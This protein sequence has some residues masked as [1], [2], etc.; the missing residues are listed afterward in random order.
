[1]LYHSAHSCS[2]A[3]TAAQVHV[4]SLLSQT[5]LSRISANAAS[6]SK[7]SGLTA[8]Q[9][10]ARI[11][12]TTSITDLEALI[13][14]HQH[15]LNQIHISAA[16]VQTS[17]LLQPGWSVSSTSSLAATTQLI[18]E[19]SD[20]QEQQLPSHPHD[21]EAAQL[22]DRLLQ[23]AKQHV[24]EFD[25]QAVGNILYCLAS[26]Q[27]YDQ[28]LVEGLL[29]RAYNIL[30]SF[31]Q[32]SI[33]QTAWALG[34][35]QCKPSDQWL[36]R[37]V[38]R[39]MQLLPAFDQQ[40][41]SLTLWGL[42][43]VDARPQLHVLK[44]F[45]AVSLP[46]L[47]SYSPQNLAMVAYSV[48]LFGY[49]PPADWLEGLYAAS[50]QQLPAFS[51]QQLATVA[52]S[53]GKMAAVEQQLAWTAGAAAS[54]A[55]AA[56]EQQQATSSRV[57]PRPSLF[58]QQ[59]VTSEEQ[60]QDEQQELA[61][62][63]EQLQSGP[64][65]PAG[66]FLQPPQQWLQQFFS[67]T[68]PLLQHMCSQELVSMLSGLAH[69]QQ[70]PPDSWLQQL[71]SFGEAKLLQ[72]G[73]AATAAILGLHARL[74][75][76]PPA[77]W[78]RSFFAASYK[79]MGSYSHQELGS[80]AHALA[81]LCIRPNA[82]WASR[83][84]ATA[85]QQMPGSAPASTSSIVSATLALALHQQ[86]EEQ[87]QQVHGLLDAA[88]RQLPSFAVP[89]LVQLLRALALSQ[90]P[91]QLSQLQQEQLLK[92]CLRLQP[93]S[94]PQT[95]AAALHC[96]ARLQVQPSSSW[97][98]QLCNQLTTRMG[99]FQASHVAVTMWSLVRMG[100]EPDR[101]W[102]HTFLDSAAGSTSDGSSSGACGCYSPQELTMVCWALGKLRFVPTQSWLA[103]F[104]SHSGTHMHGYQAQT[105]ATL[106]WMLARLPVVPG[107]AWL[108]RYAAATQPQ[109]QHC[110]PAE[111]LCLVSSV[112]A[113]R[114]QPGPAWV[115]S[116]VAAAEASEEQLGQEEWAQLQAAVSALSG[117]SRSLREQQGASS[118]S[119]SSGRSGSGSG[120]GKGS[121]KSRTKSS[122]GA[123]RGVSAGSEGI[124]NG[125]G[126]G[127]RGSLSNGSKV[128]VVESEVAAAAGASSSS[129]N[130]SGSE[131]AASCGPGDDLQAE[132]DEAVRRLQQQG[133]GMGGAVAEGGVVV[134]DEV[135][136]EL[137]R[138]SS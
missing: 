45:L 133:A 116:A 70:C 83:M 38:Q 138:N 63:Q 79:Q 56:V 124:S 87:Q 47:H 110:K 22:W 92:A 41:V 86:S 72:L 15:Q 49:C 26:Q 54:A 44:R 12:R 135:V 134:M 74:G 89:E 127:K 18:E 128:V 100:H 17:R 130:G 55:P 4:H 58:H 8:S 119:T 19:P 27:Q 64:G 95:T 2:P 50:L 21:A 111:L 117:G 51:P 30:P 29:S 59:Q 137:P 101:A 61:Q 53:L 69:L 114:A 93:H 96:L 42:A 108:Q 20:S 113:L 16:I 6:P 32:Q 37:L 118:K 7:P 39:S 31:D 14:Q 76:C 60:Q 46:R 88:V 62:Q 3:P 10:T 81:V 136:P 80:A 99:S 78:L 1:M 48:A 85:H 105:L 131:H 115:D 106:V 33:A 104:L 9:V 57:A 97:L 107:T 43:K 77:A 52:W 68:E 90:P 122:G 11:K 28:Q 84:L 36:R 126:N 123:S 66:L 112:A 5:D 25:A 71:H 23:L 65:R 120:S 129:S 35:L 34:K 121:S 125:I 91:V 102:V 98:R 94:K 103:S 75:C 67:Q 13:S 73:P 82:A 109:L 132:F 24:Q 40:H